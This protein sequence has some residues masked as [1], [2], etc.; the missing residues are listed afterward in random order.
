MKITRI[1]LFNFGSYAGKN[2]FDLTSN[3][4]EQRVIVIGGKNGAG[5]TTLFTAIEIGLYG[6]YAF[7]FKTAGRHYLKQ[8]YSL[9][10]NQARV[11]DNETAYVELSFE[12]IV[13]SEKQNYCVKRLWSWNDN[14]VEEQLIVKRNNETLEHDALT[15]FQ[16][17]LIHLIPPDLLKLYFLMV[18]RLLTIFLVIKLLTS[19]TL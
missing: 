11:D 15:N 1:E 4:A 16:N 6:N 13:N 10:N 17:Y 3:K 7:G 12:H 18:R 19:K 9:I 5:K 14:K 2:V 8:V